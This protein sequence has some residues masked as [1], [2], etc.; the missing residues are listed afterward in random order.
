MI[1]YG[2]GARV[3]Q[4]HLRGEEKYTALKKEGL[5]SGDR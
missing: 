5:C 3:S 4:Q 2:S 1:K